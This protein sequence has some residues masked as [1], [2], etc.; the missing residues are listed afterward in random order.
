V[1][2]GRDGCIT[3]HFRAC[4]GLSAVITNPPGPLAKLAARREQYSSC[5]GYGMVHGGFWSSVR[6]YAVTLAFALLGTILHANLVITAT[7]TSLSTALLQLHCCT[8]ART[9][10]LLYYY[11]TVRHYYYLLKMVYK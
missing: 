8:A 10:V 1:S 7:M 5:G 9:A 4:L 6:Q 3:R 2:D 11:T